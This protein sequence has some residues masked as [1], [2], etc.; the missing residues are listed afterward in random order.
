MWPRDLEF[1]LGLWLLFSPFIFGHD[2]GATG[3]WATDLLC[4]AFVLIVA[5][6]AYHPRLRYV[7]LAQLL[8]ALWLIVGG[9]LAAQE[10]F[11][12]ASQNQIVVGLLIAM[13]AIVPSK[14][15]QPPEAWRRLGDAG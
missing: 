9:W 11:P 14:T 12:P 8:P 15:D 13:I 10:G 5:L 4:G 2:D 6:L 7:H 1:S 3:L